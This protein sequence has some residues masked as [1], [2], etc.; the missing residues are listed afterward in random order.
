MPL[1]FYKRFSRPPLDSDIPD[2]FVLATLHR[3]ENTDDPNR[4]KSIVAALNEVNSSI[5]PVIVPLHPRTKSKIDKL[6]LKVSFEVIE[7]VGYFEMLWLLEQTELVLTDSGGVQKEAFFFNKACVTM[8]DQ[9]EWVELIDAGVNEL[10][11][12]DSLAIVA[13]VRKQYGRRVS[14]N[15]EL[16]GGGK[17][18]KRIVQSLFS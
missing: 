2:S 15:N 16:Y 12:A 8:R 13:S 11:G 17:A 18:S 4:L 9:T 14:D 10:V 3:A 1:F 6:R 5:A 7:P